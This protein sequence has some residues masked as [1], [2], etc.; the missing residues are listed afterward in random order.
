MK[1]H[2]QLSTFNLLER[3]I[4]LSPE[5]MIVNAFQR[6]Y[7]PWLLV[8]LLAQA[9][10]YHIRS[11]NDC[12]QQSFLLKIRRATILMTACSKRRIVISAERIGSSNCSYYYRIQ[13]EMDQKLVI[14]A[15]LVFGT[16]NSS[17]QAQEYYQKVLTCLI[18][19]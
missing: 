5:G 19:E 18:K 14:D 13:A 2:S 9:G 17:S 15:E 7:P 8:E 11:Q 3:I 12:R 4:G 6:A 16:M 10:S 1:I